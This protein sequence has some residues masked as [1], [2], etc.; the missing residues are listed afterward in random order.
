[1]GWTQTFCSLYVCF[2]SSVYILIVPATGYITIAEWK[3]KVYLIVSL[4]FI[5]FSGLLGLELFLVSIGENKPTKKRLPTKQKIIYVL[6]VIY[7]GFTCLSALVS[8]FPGTFLGNNRN[9]GVLTISLYVLS[10]LILIRFFRPS[11]WFLASFGG[12]VSVACVIGILQ[13]AG[14]N[15]FHFYPGNYNFYD[16]GIFYA[17]QFW[18]TVGNTNLCSA[19]LSVSTAVFAATFIR[20]DGAVRQW[21]SIP[22]ILS[23]FSIIEL[24]SE[25]GLVALMV[26]LLV[27]LPFVVLNERHVFHV[28]MMWGVISLVCAAAS[29]LVFY[30]GGVTLR[31]GV[32]AWFA[33][34]VGLFLVFLG[35]VLDKRFPTIHCL[36]WRKIRITLVCFVLTAL[37]GALIV[38]YL[39]DRFPDGFLRQAHE[40]LHG[41][42]DDDFGSGRIYIWRQVWE[43]VKEAPLLGGG[44]DTLGLRELVPFSRFSEELGMEIVGTI[45]VAHNE[46]LNILVNQGLLSLLPYL[47]ALILTFIKWWRDAE[48]NAVAICGCAMLFYSIQ[49]F[50]GISMCVTAPYLWVAIAI[51]NINC[52]NEKGESHEKNAKTFSNQSG[53]THAPSTISGNSIRRR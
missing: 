43:L 31:L 15:P 44:P 39:Y 5:L 13:L 17:N 22:L 27:M 20:Y 33:F 49:A 34:A 48:N 26:G 24:N 11:R 23:I 28:V 42:L 41:N 30:N 21:S 10:T 37:C 52:T 19:L 6:L 7:L 18:S 29:V 35:W 9:D 1:M 47:A 36:S 25:A 46:Y 38:V 14:S 32:G 50:F 4:T 16:A 51:I 2:I 3:S 40:I 45:D 53:N 12:A 8:P